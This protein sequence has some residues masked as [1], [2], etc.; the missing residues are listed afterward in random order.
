MM[1][2]TRTQKSVADMVFSSARKDRAAKRGDARYLRPILRELSCATPYDWEAV[3]SFFRTHHLPDLESVDEL[4]YERVVSMSQGMGWFRVTQDKKHR[5]L[6]LSVW[7]GGEEDIDKIS[8]AVRRMFDLDAEPDVLREAMSADPFLL[9]VWR[10]HPGLR[11]ARSW[12]GFEA[13][14][15]TTLGQLVSVRFGRTLTG[16][17]MKAAGAKRL[18]PRT[19]EPIHLFPTAKQILTADLSGIRTSE[20]RRATIRSLARLVDDGTLDW[21]QPVPAK[22]LRS[23]LLAVPGVGAWTSEYLAMRGFN[24]ND[25]F[26]ATDYGLKQELKRHP[27]ID[28]NRVRPWRAYAATALW[29]SFAE[30]KGAS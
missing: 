24:D 18:H 19:S 20:S 29:K 22:T 8:D 5:S 21:K 2:K 14:F 30:A 15:T 7:N 27:E 25:A 9:S 12:N 16:E 26:P 17:L 10:R 11:V 3:L 6:R 23:I 1:A 4:G 28:V 13:M